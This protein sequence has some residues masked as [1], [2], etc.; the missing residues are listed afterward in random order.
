MFEKF[1]REDYIDLVLETAKEVALATGATHP[2]DIMSSVLSTIEVLYKQSE[3]MP[4]GMIR[5]EKS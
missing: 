3:R 2:H 5:L 4:Y 1:N